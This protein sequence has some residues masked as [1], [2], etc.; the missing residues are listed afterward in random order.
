LP[1]V[2][3]QAGGSFLLKRDS[4]FNRPD[5]GAAV[6]SRVNEPS[7]GSLGDVIFQTGNWYAAVSAD[8]GGSFRYIDPDETFP[9]FPAQFS[10]GLC[11]DQ[12]VAQ[13][14]SR[15]LLFWYLQ[16]NIPFASGTSNGVR[17]AV[18]HG[19]NDAA[20]NR[21]TFCSYTPEDFGFESGTLLDFPH[22]QVGAKYLY[23]TSNVESMGPD[24]QRI[25]AI[26]ARFPLDGLANRS[27]AGEFFSYE[28]PENDFGG[29]APVSG[30][31]SRMVFASAASTSTLAIVDWAETAA[32]NARLRMVSVTPSLSG[33]FQ[34]PG[35]D[36]L[37]PCEN[38]R[39]R[40]QTG[41]L[42]AT[43]LGFMRHSP[44]GTPE[45]PYPF[46]RVVILNPAS[47][48]VLSES[49][50][51]SQDFAVQYPSVAV[52]ARGHIGGIAYALGGRGFPAVYA[53]LRDDLSPDQAS[54]AWEIHELATSSDGAAEWGDYSG[55][56]INARFPNTWLSGGH[57]MVGG[58]SNTDV[59]PHN[60]WFMRTRD[61]PGSPGPFL[62]TP[63]ATATTVAN[64]SIGTVTPS[65][66]ATATRTPAPVVSCAGVAGAGLLA[67]EGETRGP[68]LEPS[69]GASRASQVPA[70]EVA[71]A[72]TPPR[73]TIDAVPYSDQQ[74]RARA[75]GGPGP[76]WT[77]I[78]CET[79]EVLGTF[80]TL[81]GGWVPSD[82][83]HRSD[84]ALCW[85]KHRY[86]ARYGLY[87]LWP[88]GG[89][90]CDN[91]APPALPDPSVNFYPN[92]MNS[93]LT[94]GPF[95]LADADAADVHFS[96][97]HQLARGTA[98]EGSDT[99][100]WGASTNGVN[101]SGFSLTGNSTN[102]EPPTESGWRDIGFDLSNY[103]GRSQ[104]WVAF[105]FRSNGQSVD[106]GPFLDDILIEKLPRA[107]AATLTAGPAR[108][109][110]RTPTGSPTASTTPLPSP[111]VPLGGR[112]LGLTTDPSGFVRLTWNPGTGQVGYVVVRLSAQGTTLLPF[113]APFPS[114]AT[115][116]A[117]VPPPGLTC[118]IVVPIRAEGTGP[119]VNSDPVCALTN[120]H[121]ATGAPQDF[122]L[123]LNESN[124]ATLSWTAPPGG[125]QDGYLLARFGKAPILL[126]AQAT[127]TTD[128]MTGMTCYAVIAMRGG[129]P[130]GNS[131]VLCGIP[132]TPSLASVP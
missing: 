85:G 42:T 39:A 35:P 51:W 65:L 112:G 73:R 14:P 127:G 2:T 90:V 97:W 5:N 48:V 47:L 50:I 101:F 53:L 38:S 77:T 83:N 125:G 128:L 18:A 1:E 16:Y 99:L 124:V 71:P 115:S 95:S 74:P 116:H 93:W 98:E 119:P 62:P 86:Q 132:R 114:T 87:S 34:C 31:T 69:F 3:A 25:A 81:P 103:V 36:G 66:T 123:R 27:C 129:V 117:D 122:T 60:F 4:V 41:W 52:N 21:W 130:V 70:A 100:F 28:K 12:R 120:T 11:C 61:D 43:E 111:T 56:T 17:L 76:G 40:T 23:F 8:N 126:D 46:V 15:N 7:V 68:K 10:A 13:D 24:R 58:S 63:S 59:R 44:G 104:V 108:T 45:R 94:Y 105:V 84:F 67:I 88:A 32:A 19:T 49:D 9:R 6:F 109:A 113:G 26:V 75:A 78:T 29:L 33:P 91:A 72:E 121:S 80:S 96:L 110:T 55:T 79:A 106:D 20:A 89:T 82:E 54:R 37:D 102:H 118:Y 57:V 107:T 22:M 64:P 30:A 131:D 92:N